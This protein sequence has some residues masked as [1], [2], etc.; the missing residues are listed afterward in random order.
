MA[1][2]SY[3]TQVICLS[4]HA[5]ST[6]DGYVRVAKPAPD[7][8]TILTTSLRKRRSLVHSRFLLDRLV[9]AVDNAD[10]DIFVADHCYMAE[11]VLASRRFRE[12]PTSGS[13]MAVS[14]VVPEALVWKATRGIVGHIDARRIGRDEIRVARSA[15]SVGTY[16][17]EE[18]QFYARL[19]IRR[20]HWLDL[21]LSPVER[22]AVGESEPRLVFMGDRRWAPNQEAFETL[23]DWWPRIAAG[24]EGATLCVVGA[25]D[26]EATVRP[27][28]PSMTDL[29]FVDDLEG[30]LTASRALVAPIR[31]G[32]GVRVKILDAARRGLPVVGTTAAVG[33][34]GTVLGI[35]KFDDEVGFINICRRYLLDRP[36]AAKDGA[37]LYDANATRWQQRRPHTS[38]Q[39]WLRR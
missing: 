18:A 25:R 15:Y 5:G 13:C 27:L 12:D 24:I 1:R 7:A 29:G 2:E 26:A 22:A 19:G 28:P 3:Q 32:G 35:G 37:A 34:L 21:T 31:T 33:S 11:S 14:T 6:V 16:D 8:R 39:E 9:D 36:A 38:V 17:A 4:A 20:A 23:I 10:T 30:L